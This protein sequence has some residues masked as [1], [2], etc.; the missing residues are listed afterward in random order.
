M[1]CSLADSENLSAQ[2]ENL[3]NLGYEELD[4]TWRSVFGSERPRR[5]CG[6]L[7]IK[8]LGYR[9]QE[10][11]IG[12]LKLSTR[13]QLERWGRNGSERGPSAEPARTQLKAG[14]GLVRE[15]HGVTHR[16]TV[17][18]DGF[19][20]DGERFRSLSEIARKITGVRWSGPLFFGP[21]SFAKEQHHGAE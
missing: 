13:R 20:F 12:G 6:D 4:Q 7:L 16:V 21:K 19:D 9:L 2:I 11:A 8:A 10:K 15:W 1:K 17:L 5:V 3:G 14:T 18:D